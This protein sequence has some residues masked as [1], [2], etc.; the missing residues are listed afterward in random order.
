MVWLLWKLVWW[1]LKDYYDPVIPFWGMYPKEFTAGSQRDI[2]T[3]PSCMHSCV[4]HYVQKVEASQVDWQMNRQA[5]CHKNVQGNTIQPSKAR[6]LGHKLQCGSDTS[7]NG[8]IQ[9]LNDKNYMF[10][11]TWS[12]VT[13]H[14]QRNESKVTDARGYREGK[15]GIAV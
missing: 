6:K 15:W 7:V 12:S 8:I 11:L 1:F 10:S 4:I 13:S 3:P 2:C 9:P 14:T 5:K